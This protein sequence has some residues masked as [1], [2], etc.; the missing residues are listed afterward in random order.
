MKLD[1]CFAAGLLKRVEPDMGNAKRSLQ[2]SKEFLGDASKNNEI[3]RYKVV[4]I[5][6][7]TAMFHAARA[8][9][10]RDGIKER[11]HICPDLYQGRIP[12]AG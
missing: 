5:L 2:V 11:S 12:P 3:E 1:E 6:G 9:L 7:Y 10:F 8:L 4:V